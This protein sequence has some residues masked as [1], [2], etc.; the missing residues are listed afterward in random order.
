MQAL[1]GVNG[2]GGESRLRE[3]LARLDLCVVID[4]H[5][6]ATAQLADF[7]LGLQPQPYVQHTEAVTPPKFEC[8]PAQS[9]AKDEPPASV[10]PILVAVLNPEYLGWSMAT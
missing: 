5:P 3:A 6:K 2:I 7:A 8:R 4:R 9:R 10:Q 1:S